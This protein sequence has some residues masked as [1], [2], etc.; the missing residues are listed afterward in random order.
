M[1]GR[2]AFKVSFKIS[3]GCK[4]GGLFG[5]HAVLNLVSLNYI[6][7]LIF[8]SNYNLLKTT[9]NRAVDTSVQNLLPPI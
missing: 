5:E 1:L 6:F 3:A 4:V 2:L 9:G 7:V 8:S